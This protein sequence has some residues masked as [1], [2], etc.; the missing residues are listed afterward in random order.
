MPLNTNDQSARREKGEEVPGAMTPHHPGQTSEEDDRLDF[1]VTEAAEE[2]RD[3]AGGYT[4]PT[5]DLQATDRVRV[6]ADEDSPRS[7]HALLQD[8]IEEESLTGSAPDEADPPVEAS[9]QAPASYSTQLASA[10]RH[11][12]ETSMSASGRIRKLSALEIK[13]IERN[14]SQ[15]T[16]YLSEDE[17]QSLLRSFS[18]TQPA[19]NQVQAVNT[20]PGAR[21]SVAPPPLKVAEQADQPQQV[22]PKASD[23]VRGLAYYTGSFIQV[24]GG[25][26]LHDGDEVVINER[27]YLLRRKRLSSMT[28]IMILSPIV[29]GLLFLLGAMFIGGGSGKGQVVGIVF[30]QQGVPYQQGATVS[31]P[32]LG[33][34]LTTNAEGWFQ[35]EKLAVGSHR[36]QYV[37][38]GT[39]VS[40]DFVT[41]VANEP[42][43]LSLRP[44]TPELPTQEPLSDLPDPARPEPAP[45]PEN[46]RVTSS[47]RPQR[48]AETAERP[49]RT[50]SKKTGAI[51]L[52]ANVDGAKLEI[53]GRPVGSGNLTYQKIAPGNRKYSITKPGYEPVIGMVDVAAGQTLKLEVDMTPVRSAEVEKRSPLA[54]DLDNARALFESGKAEE[55]A[56]SFTSII[57][58][59]PEASA[60]YLGRA[61]S[62]LAQRNRSAAHR[63]F[64]QAATILTG[65]GDHSA[66]LSAFNEAIEANPKSPDGYLGR[67][68]LLLRRGESIGAVADFEAVISIDR[69]NAP[70]YA[71]LGKAR[72]AQGNFERA[73]KHLKDAR[74]LAPDDPEILENLMKAYF[75]NNDVKN[76][77]KT[78]DTYLKT[79]TAPEQQRFVADRANQ[80]LLA[81]AQRDIATN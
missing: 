42:T 33:I 36:V 49:A 63:D 19:A 34:N 40:E 59:H 30:D 17:K 71:G 20:A 74:S 8:L 76:L 35:S 22:R 70:A 62:E 38:A 43:P 65:N 24:I 56:T 3:L 79:A 52:A 61:A 77:R 72:L 41:V 10:T 11:Q 54:I 2:H 44:T 5:G 50:Q 55:A 81:I 60:A 1:V 12:T 46:E 14:L 32:D 78:W 80:A 16:P 45:V 23:K 6:P 25:Q 57:E 47:P 15:T 73:I 64:I 27:H 31:F 69:R 18:A 37:V 67:A 51:I 58:Q 9:E 7:Q 4:P 48:E 21:Q 68:S 26:P 53:D 75:G 13:S 29:A 66:A 39:V 28:L